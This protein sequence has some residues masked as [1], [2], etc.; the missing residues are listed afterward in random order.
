MSFSISDVKVK[1]C[2]Q[3]IS[4]KTL[5]VAVLPVSESV[6][7][8]FSTL[9]LDSREWPE[10]A[11]VTDGTDGNSR[12]AVGEYTITIA[13]SPLTI[14]AA[15]RGKTVQTLTVCEKTGAIGFPLGKGPLFGLGHG[16]A[17]PMNRRGAKFDLRVNGQVRG[18]FENYSA[19]SPTPYVI[20]TE[21][22]ALYFHQPWKGT[23]DLS[24]ETQGVF[25]KYP[26]PY[27]DVFM[28]D[29]ET[30]LDAPREYYAFTGNHPMLPKYAF[31][32]QQSYRTLAYKGVNYVEKTAQYMRDNDIPCD[33]LIY[34]GTGYCENG[35]NTYNGNFEWHPDVFPNPKETM[36][37]LHGMNYKISLH[38]TRC[39]TGLHGS[40]HD[41]GVSPLV[42][43]HA[44]NYWQ[45]HRELYATAKN[46]VWW[47]D[48]ADEV[49]ME[50][51]L[52]RHRMYYEGCMDMVPGVR[53]FQMQRNTFP[54]ANKYGGVIW[55]GDI[56]AEWETLKNQVPIGLN[57]ALSSSAYWGTD[58][59]GFF[60]TPELDGELYM[61][62]VEYSTFT[63]FFRAHGRP[64]FLHN[65]WGWNMFES[66]DDMPLEL[67]PGLRHDGA[68]KAEALKDAR[69]EPLCRKYI[70]LRY[71]LLPYIYSAAHDATEGTPIMRPLWC[72]A[73]GDKAALETENEYF[74]GDSLLVAP[75]TEK[76]AKTRKVYL[77]G[78][79]WYDYW[80]GEAYEGGKAYD[81][82]APIE[83][84]PLFAKAGGILT[85]APVVPY[86]D[87]EKK[88]T[89][90][91]VSLAVYT[92]AN[93][94]YALYEDDGISM[95]YQQGV[96]TKTAFQW[97]DQ[98]GNLTA[99][100]TSTQF[101]GQRRTI[102]YTLMPSGEERQIT[103]QY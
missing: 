32:Y 23:I 17:T 14:T 69:V 47:P 77:P 49:D 43:D 41:E 64:S 91:P 42:Y 16:Y 67:S 9:D 1:I 26:R 84:I 95:D 22:W 35:W 28:V 56:L 97:D 8:V 92:G 79:K 93:G 94:T 74:F 19:T 52:A 81:V 72:Y 25:T 54:G 27:A 44:K 63:P 102:S 82:A 6:K 30:P 87:T 78:G 68:P 53:P 51:R 71:S 24:N 55:S 101:P 90:D 62:W 66:L 29:L 20:S 2:F 18:I 75:V 100:G 34:L 83:T 70:H 88:D 103:I 7:D 5:R 40:I 12:F 10:P 36:E 57:V 59:G 11:I 38:V 98:A 86:V 39:Y 65:P 33:V 58:T 96:C 50:E 60:S 73:P 48:D 31:G 61:R 85:K 45:K 89:F 13:E 3:P 76:G 99:K 46:E 80:S 21:G 37:R 4:G 15:R